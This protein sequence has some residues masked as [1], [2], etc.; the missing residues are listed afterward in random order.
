MDNNTPNDP[1]GSVPFPFPGMMYNDNW[2]QADNQH[3]AMHHLAVIEDMA[4]HV[5][6]ALVSMA[7]VVECYIDND[8]G[9]WDDVATAVHGLFGIRTGEKAERF[10]SR[11]IRAV[12]KVDAMRTGA[13]PPDAH[14]SDQD[15]V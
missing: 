2:D 10:F 8:G 5:T 3:F 12:A 7:G 1:N 13:V 11:M 4:D 14:D 15:G 6:N 9:S